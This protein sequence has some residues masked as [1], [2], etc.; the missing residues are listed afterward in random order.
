MIRLVFG[1]L[2]IGGII[3]LIRKIRKIWK[4]EDRLEAQDNFT[5]TLES[6]DDKLELIDRQNIVVDKSIKLKEK[7]D[8]VETKLGE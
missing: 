7:I 8:S 6:L 4:R 1:L 5:E 3:L 2:L